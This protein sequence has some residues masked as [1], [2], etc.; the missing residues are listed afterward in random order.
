M[1]S[2]LARAPRLLWLWAIFFLLVNIVMELRGGTNPHSRFALLCAMVED[3][4][5]RIDPYHDMTVD[6]ARTPDGHYY[7]NKAPGPALI[8]LPIFWLVDKAT[9]AGIADR[10]RRDQRRIELRWHTERLLSILLQAIPFA[11]LVVL[12]GTWLIEAGASTAAVQ[13]FCA[14]ALFGN[15]AALFMNTFFG[16][17]MTAAATLTLAL[18]LWRRSFA[19]AGFFFGLSV[20]CDFGSAMLLPAVLVVIALQTRHLRDWLHWALGGVLPGAAWSAYHIA[21]FGSP[22][23]LPTQYQNPI[24]VDNSQPHVWGVIDR[25]PHL[26]VVGELLFGPSRGILF[27]QPWLLAALVCLPLLLVR[28]RL[29]SPST[30]V[31]ALL[32]LAG[33]LAMNAAFG[34][35][36][37][38]NTP[39]PRYLCA[40]FP[41]TALAVALNYDRLNRRWRYA[42]WAGQA[43]S[44]ALAIVVFS[45]MLDAEPGMPLWRFYAGWLA[46]GHWKT[47]CVRGPILALGWLMLLRQGPVST[48]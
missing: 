12:S 37:A 3:H 27:T 38:G 33:L 26:R 35:W 11:L 31:F 39:G 18:A 1:R 17:G 16:H 46:A 8:G 25:L 24:F 34:Q 41:A 40:I 30:T 6:W 48:A 36:H 5:L 32:G 44:L 43:V 29:A 7:S 19:A 47:L 21:A 23:T 20:L 10:A 22:F 42:L 13:F 28:K 14:A 15:T 9:T 45:T 2:P 4:S